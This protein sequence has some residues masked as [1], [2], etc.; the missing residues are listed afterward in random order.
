MVGGGNGSGTSVIERACVKGISELNA[1]CKS[2]EVV[3]G[4]KR[5]KQRQELALHL[6]NKSRGIRS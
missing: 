4:G 5:E 1:T 2:E 3:R 6:S